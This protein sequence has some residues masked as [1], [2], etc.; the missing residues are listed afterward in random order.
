MVKVKTIV[1]AVAMALVGWS[2]LALDSYYVV[3]ITDMTGEKTYEVMR[4]YFPEAECVPG[5]AKA[6]ER[7]DELRGEGEK[8][9]ICGSFYMAE[10]ALRWMGRTSL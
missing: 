1:A 8:V 2:A 4:K 7:A 9:L 3:T 6:I 10:E 5:V